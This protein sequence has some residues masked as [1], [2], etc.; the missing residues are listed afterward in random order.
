MRTKHRS[1]WLSTLVL[2]A[3]LSIGARALAEDAPPA[4]QE[5]HSEA[6]ATEKQTAPED[7]ME[8]GMSGCMEDGKMCDSDMMKHCE[9]KMGKGGCK[10]MMKKM[11]HKKTEDK[12]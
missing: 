2:I 5:H 4:H 3:T 10:K 8:H 11:K 6:P 12:K 9:K 7:K 1:T